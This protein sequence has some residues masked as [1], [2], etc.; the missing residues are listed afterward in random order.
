MAVT[1]KVRLEVDAKGF[2]RGLAQGEARFDQ[3]TSKVSQISG[4]LGTIGTVVRGLGILEIGQAAIQ[5]GNLIADTIEKARV[6]ALE[7]S[8]AQAGGGRE[9]SRSRDLLTQAAQIRENAPGATGVF[10]DRLG[11]F[12]GTIL[13]GTGAGFTG[14]GASEA[15]RENT[16]AVSEARDSQLALAE[17]LER[18][19]LANARGERFARQQIPNFVGQ[20]QQAGVPA[21]IIKEFEKTVRNQNNILEIQRET[22]RAMERAAERLARTAGLG[23]LGSSAAGSVR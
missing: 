19:A 13:G 3:F 18:L 10:F 20:L 5:V 22:A 9:G 23:L 12:F 15:I 21:D 8:V 17:E 14:Q 4:T 6:R 16:D 11:A 1:E 2:A 7:F